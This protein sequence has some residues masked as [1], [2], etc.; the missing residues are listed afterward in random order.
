MKII[1]ALERLPKDT[2]K[3]TITVPWL[4]IKKVYEK[5]LEKKIKEV[6]ISG[7]RK[8]KAPLSLAKKQIAKEPL[9][10][11]TLQEILPEIY[12]EAVKE[13]QLKPIIQP[14]IQIIVMEEDKDWQ[15]TATTCEK[16][17][18]TLGNYQEE[19]KNTLNAPKI[20]VPGKE[21]KEEKISESE[22]TQKL[23]EALLKAVKIE[24]P[25][26]LIEDETSRLLSSFL[27][28]INKL[29]LT[30]DSYLNSVKKTAEQVRKEHQE[31]AERV[32]KLEF[33]LEAIADDLKVEVQEKEIDEL[34]EKTIKTKEEKKKLKINKYYFASIIRRQKTLDKLLNL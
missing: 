34:I 31:R 18:A 13:H 27:D 29:G 22:K 15:L 11:E 2:L 20:L 6:E 23:F 8:G 24:L 14:K 21:E 9:L 3:I 19:I 1:S 7:F 28:Q 16:P 30:L 5:V 4:A 33:V 12:T 10:E 25:Q 32:L 17:K 26:I